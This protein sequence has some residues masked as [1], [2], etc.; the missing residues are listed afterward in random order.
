LSIVLGIV[1]WAV[2]ALARR[3]TGHTAA[4]AA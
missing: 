1:T 3:F 2:L 4:A